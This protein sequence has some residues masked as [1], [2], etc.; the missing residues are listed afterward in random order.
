MLGEIFRTHPYRLWGPS[1]LLY[2]GYRFSF[3]GLNWPWS[4]VDYPPQSRVV[5][6]ERVELDLY[7]LSGPSWHVIREILHLP[8]SAYMLQVLLTRLYIST[9]LN[10][11]WKNR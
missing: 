9:G 8:S 11:V 4:G 5:V 6:E 10:K 3:P 1:S 2:S 7:S